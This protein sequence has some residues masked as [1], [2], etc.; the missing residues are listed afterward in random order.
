MRQTVRLG[1]VAGI[2]VGANWSVIV[3]LAII[4]D[5]LA[6][7][8]LPAEVRHQ[9]AAVYWTAG[10]IT[11]VLF[12]AALLTHEL[13][14]ALVA[15]H[16]GVGVRSITLWGLGGVSE[17]EGDPPSAGAD[18]RIALAGPAASLAAAG[19]FFG[20][21][22]VIGQ[23]R[24]PD[25]AVAAASWLG[26]M[27]GLLAF[28]NL[29]P[30][31]PLDG[32]RVLRA[33]LWRRYGDRDRAA[34][35]AARSGRYLGVL[36]AVLGIAELLVTGD[37]LGGLW[38]M[39][40][41]WFLY[42][43]AAAEEAAVA[44]S[45]ALRGLRVADVMTPDPE[46]APGWMTVAD[47]AGRIAAARSAQR[48]FPVLSS[49]ARLVGVVVTAQLAR[50]SRDQRASWRVQQAALPV[51]DEYLVAPGDPASRMA[52]RSPLGGEVVA[53]VLDHGRIVGMVTAAD[54]HQAQLRHRLLAD[55]PR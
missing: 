16:D 8:I 46:I 24:G 39:L 53:V 21:A 37:F 17:L 42:S 3:I 33:A 10:C 55:T 29:L 23:A 27:N 40:I 52:A 15:R 19:V 54:M 51:P 31:A 45:V 14:H 1:R 9:S 48:A 13:S 47:F 30:G 18:L 7:S 5:M 41:G 28:F 36:L 6:V 4:A 44:S 32:G 20:V 22:A 12:L 35:S 11:A 50:L 34:T 38:L 43:A 25:I 26:V 49:D 2:P